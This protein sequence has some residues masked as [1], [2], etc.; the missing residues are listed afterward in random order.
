MGIEGCPRT[1]ACRHVL[2]DLAIGDTSVA[3]V[4][5]VDEVRRHL[6]TCPPCRRE[7][8]ALQAIA[9]ALTPPPVA[10]AVVAQVAAS[11]TTLVQARISAWEARRRR[12]GWAAGLAAVAALALAAIGLWPLGC[13]RAPVV[14]CFH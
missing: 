6:A 5:E 4:G 13:S 10:D 7:L 14:L 3:D 12:L 8:D 2:L 11:V 9:A 1:S